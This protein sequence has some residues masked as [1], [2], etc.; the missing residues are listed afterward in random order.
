MV[1]IVRRRGGN[2][3]C[4]GSAFIWN[5][6]MFWRKMLF[7]SSFLRL[8]C[9]FVCHKVTI[10]TQNVMCALSSLMPCVTY[11]KHPSVTSHGDRHG[12]TPCQSNSNHPTAARF[13]WCDE[14][15]SKSWIRQCRMLRV[16]PYH[17]CLHNKKAVLG[18]PCPFKKEWRSLIICCKD[19]NIFRNFQ[20]LGQKMQRN[21]I[22][23][24]EFLLRSDIIH[25]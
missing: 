15:R 12:V 14:D 13:A 19:R 11:L 9:I 23:C 20:I 2:C 4:K 5:S 6:Q 17:R 18:R 8:F 24:W 3:W 25:L 7:W 1:R 10:L 21:Y 16:V 22:F